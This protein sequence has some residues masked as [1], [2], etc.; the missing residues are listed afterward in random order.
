MTADDDR[1]TRQDR[2]LAGVRSLHE[3]VDDAVRPLAEMHRERLQCRSGCAAC[4]LDGLSVFEVEASRI[5]AEHA[6]LLAHG[7]A[8]PPGACAFLGDTNECRIYQSRPQVCRSQGLP[9][10]W[11]LEDPAGEIVEQR[12]ICELNVEGPAVDELDEDECWLI[13]PTEGRL[14]RLQAGL[15]G[16]GVRRVLLRDLFR[17]QDERAEE[18]T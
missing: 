5:E 2:A 7:T 17:R 8:H 1:A 6:E 15:D 9:L 16:E 4:C 12:S 13:G 11:Y 3:D 14:I 10:R 18:E